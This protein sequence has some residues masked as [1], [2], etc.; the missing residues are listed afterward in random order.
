VEAGGDAHVLLGHGDDTGRVSRGSPVVE[1]GYGGDRFE[2]WWEDFLSYSASFTGVELLGG[3]GRDVLAWEMDFP[4][5][6]DTRETSVTAR[7]R[8]ATFRS[9]HEFYGGDL[10]DVMLGHRG[11]DHFWGGF[12]DDVLRGRGGHDILVG[13]RGDDVLLGGH[14]RDV[15]RGMKGVDTCRAEVRHG[16]ER[17]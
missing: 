12:G 15:A 9:I 10:D 5:R 17:R 14:G 13:S 4:V 1:G 16:C 2:L 6:I 11:H 8:D 7:H 3:P